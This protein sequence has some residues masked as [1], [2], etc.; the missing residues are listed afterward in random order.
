MKRIIIIL[1]ALILM[2]TCSTG[3]QRPAW[4]PAASQSP[5]P[6]PTP[7][8]PPMTITDKKLELDGN[9]F[10]FEATC[11]NDTILTIDYF[12]VNIY[13]YDE[14]DN[15]LDSTYTNWSGKLLPGGSAKVEKMIKDDGKIK[16]Y[17]ATISD[18]SYGY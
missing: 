10:Y 7:R 8:K 6:E 4:T 13:L 2:S 12:E 15:S 9:Y 17:S 14:N 5:T 16:R 3:Y 18:I 11:R 1:A